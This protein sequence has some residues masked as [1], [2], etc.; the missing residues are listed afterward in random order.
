MESM[1]GAAVRSLFEKRGLTVREIAKTSGA[2]HASV[3]RML[4]GGGITF[5]TARRL[6]EAFDW[7]TYE[8][9]AVSVYGKTT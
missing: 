4:D 9:L 7:L 5:L 1:D 8:T 3:Q 6:V 2:T